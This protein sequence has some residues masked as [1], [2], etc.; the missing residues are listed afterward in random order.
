MKNLT[1]EALND[2]RR[3]TPVK[4]RDFFNFVDELEK[5]VKNQVPGKWEK[6]PKEGIFF[7]TIWQQSIGTIKYHKTV[8]TFTNMYV[9]DKGTV[10]GTHGHNRLVHKKL[11][12][13]YD[14]K[15]MRELYII[16]IPNL[17][18][19][20]KFCDKN[21]VHHLCNNYGSPIYVISAKVTGRG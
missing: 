16:Y 2:I 19:D 4:K 7:S 17:L 9:P 18:V 13:S 14:L 15:K 20:M 5:I 11:D 1:L 21:E 6:V 8:H 10:I 3:L 12:N